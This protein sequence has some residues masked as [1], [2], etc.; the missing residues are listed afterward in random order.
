MPLHSVYRLSILWHSLPVGKSTTPNRDR[1]I[2]PKIL[3]LA[4][5]ILLAGQQFAAQAAPLVYFPDPTFSVLSRKG[6]PK[7]IT[8]GGG[9]RSICP[10]LTNISPDR[11]LTP[12]VPRDT[13]GGLSATAT[14]T[15]WVYFPYTTETAL[16]G[17]LSIRSTDNFRSEPSQQVPVTLP[18][19]PGLVKLKLPS[20][21]VERGMLAWTLTVVC[22]SANRSRNPFVSGLVMVKPNPQLLER[23]GNLPQSS[24]AAEFARWGY[25]YDALDLV[26]GTDGESGIKRLMESKEAIAGANALPPTTSGVVR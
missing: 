3:G 6:T 17:V 15:F 4:V 24:Q 25:W 11:V 18:A 5:T 1:Q 14:P 2:L 8:T 19:Q 20:A 9:K 12:I 23:V 26:A 13:F 10:S 22:D 16:A 7:D 21:I